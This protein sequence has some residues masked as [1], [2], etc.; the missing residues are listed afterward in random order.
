MIFFVAET[1]KIV[2]MFLK[3]AVFVHAK[4]LIFNLLKCKFISSCESGNSF[5]FR[6]SGIKSINI[7]FSS[8]EFPSE[9]LEK[10]NFGVVTSKRVPVKPNQ[11]KKEK[12][13][14][15]YPGV[16]VHVEETTIIQERR[17]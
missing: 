3:K 17:P 11:C 12:R 16:I 7:Y 4:S 15:D 9:T 13:E 10:W 14:T 2:L 8:R 5:I 1:H 6:R